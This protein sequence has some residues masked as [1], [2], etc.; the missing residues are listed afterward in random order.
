MVRDGGRELLRRVYVSADRVLGSRV[1]TIVD[2]LADLRPVSH[3]SHTERGAESID[4][5]AGHAT[6]WMRVADSDSVAV[7][8]VATNAFNAYSF[9]VVLRASSLHAG[10]TATLP[11]F[12]APARGHGAA[13]TGHRRRVGRGGAV[14]ARPGGLCRNAGHVLDRAVFAGAPSAGHAGAS[15]RSSHLPPDAGRRTCLTRR[16]RRELP[17]GV[18]RTTLLGLP[19]WAAVA[20]GAVAVALVR[21]ELG[22]GACTFECH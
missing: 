14:L 4:Y 3:R 5:S 9:E 11:A 18:T 8:A 22:R 16:R 1:D 17:C 21:G 20:V 15:R 12:A 13:G 19:V 2:A 6:G 7:D 10:W